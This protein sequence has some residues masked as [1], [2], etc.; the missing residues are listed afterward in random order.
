MNNTMQPTNFTGA[1][2]INYRIARKYAIKSKRDLKA[3]LEELIVDKSNAQ[4]INNWAGK[5]YKTFYIVEDGNDKSIAEF[6]LKE[7]QNLSFIYY[8]EINKTLKAVCNNIN[9]V[10]VFLADRMTKKIYNTQDLLNCIEKEQVR[11]AISQKTSKLKFDD[12]IV[13]ILNNLCIDEF[14][15]RQRFVSGGITKIDD[16]FSIGK[17]RMSPPDKNGYRLVR[18]NANDIKAPIYRCKVDKHGNIIRYY[19]S[20]S[21]IELF[22][23]SFNKNVREFMSGKTNTRNI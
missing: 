5:D 7:I 15:G 11:S 16:K 23:R 17:L 10:K 2:E 3:E 9:K 21:D 8:P 14:P 1:F 4:I 18:V 13:K 20:A 19:I 6:I 12:I 22:S